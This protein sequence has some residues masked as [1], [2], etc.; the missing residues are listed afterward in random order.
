MEGEEEEQE[1]QGGGAWWRLY[2]WSKAW[3]LGVLLGKRWCW[4]PGWPAGQWINWL[5]VGGADGGG[6]AGGGG[7][8]RVESRVLV[9]LSIFVKF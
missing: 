8:R 6:G 1:E 9:L 4:R 7:R 2:E 3:C 5:V